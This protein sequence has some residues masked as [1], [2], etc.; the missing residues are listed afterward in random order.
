MM[1]LRA[2]IGCALQGM[3]DLAAVERIGRVG[4]AGIL[5][6]REKFRAAASIRIVRKKALETARI[7]GSAA[8]TLPG[9]CGGRGSAPFSAD[10]CGNPEANA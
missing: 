3:T 7:L 9:D 5:V 8:P 10:T 1:L 2:F 4:G 6:P